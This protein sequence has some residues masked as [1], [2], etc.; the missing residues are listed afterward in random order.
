MAG[1]A[2]ILSEAKNPGS[3]EL[4]TR[5]SKM[6]NRNWKREGSTVAQGFALLYHGLWEGLLSREEILYGFGERQRRSPQTD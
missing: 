3:A 6:E 1:G 2:V 5:N 4:E